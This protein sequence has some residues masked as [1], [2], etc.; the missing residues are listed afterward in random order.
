MSKDCSY[1]IKVFL[2]VV[3]LFSF[4]SVFSQISFLPYKAI[5]TG[6]SSEDVWI[7]DINND[8]LND[9]VMSTGTYFDPVNDYM[10]FV[11]LQ[12]SAG[13]LDSPIKYPYKKTHPGL[14]CMVVEDVNNDGR[15]DVII[16]HIG[17]VGIFFQNSSGT[18][19]SIQY[20]HSGE[21]V[22]YLTVGD[23]NND[24]LPDIAVCHTNEHFIKIFYQ[25]VAGFDSVM[26]PQPIY[27]DGEM[28]I[29]D[30][31]DDG[32]NDLVILGSGFDDSLYVYF[33]NS[34]GL[35]NGYVNILADDDAYS[36]NGFALGDISNDG[37]TDLIASKGG[38]S[39]NARVQLWVQDSV[40]HL[41]SAPVEIVAYDIP[42]P[43]DVADLNCDGQNEII[44]VNAGW[45]TVCVHE[46]NSQSK[47]DTF[48]KFRTGFNS[49]YNPTALSIGDINNDGL[50]DIAV[51]NDIHGLML[52]INNSKP[53][54]FIVVDTMESID[55]TYTV[56]H[57][58]T[59][60]YAIVRSDTVGN[61]GIRRIDTFA[62]TTA[63][64]ENRLRINTMVIRAAN[65]CS[66]MVYDTISTFVNSVVYDGE[67]TDTFL[68]SIRKD[69]TSLFGEI[70]VY[71]SP[72]E[73]LITMELPDFFDNQTE[74]TVYNKVGQLIRHENYLNKNNK[75]KLDLSICSSGIYYL[76][77][78]SAQG[79]AQEVKS[80][81][82]V[83]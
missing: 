17:N 38:N 3:G 11:F 61:Y 42:K 15:N 83:R 13:E 24:G 81:V 71:P 23:L 73:G 45:A 52:L 6:S 78:R 79:A 47:Y 65:L 77:F 57:S 22:R 5:E 19:D 60:Y 58:D 74:I 34:S 49:H 16:G 82:I 55:T 21:I 29:G 31:N 36:L 64:R 66:K 75:R 35:L 59:G 80:I 26:Y 39:P 56:L 69:S 20:F 28:E 25:T 72:S 70:K 33:Q 48:Q 2:V 1:E 51:A 9:V 43:I 50:K 54:N 40:S 44:S 30:I 8:G 53:K 27:G 14:V 32:R 37:R 68:Y 12:N 10:I 18:L 41:L 63:F 46:Q 76:K 62:V 4:S 67:R 7:K